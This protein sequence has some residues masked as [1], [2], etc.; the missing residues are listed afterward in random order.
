MR[1][2]RIVPFL[3]EGRGQHVALGSCAVELWDESVRNMKDKNGA[4]VRDDIFKGNIAEGF[5]EELE[6][7]IVE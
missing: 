7:H 5:P 2:A 6:T 4:A 3:E 1:I